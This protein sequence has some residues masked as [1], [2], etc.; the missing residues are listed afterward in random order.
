MICPH[1]QLCVCV[2][3][4]VLQ[5]QTALAAAAAAAT[6]SSGVV[7]GGNGNG[8]GGSSNDTSQITAH[9][10]HLHISTTSPYTPAT[11]T[12]HQQQ[13]TAYATPQ[14]AAGYQIPQPTAATQY[15]QHT[16]GGW[17]FSHHPTTHHHLVPQQVCIVYSVMSFNGAL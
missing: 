10:N 3:V 9:L 8:G 12:H 15:T 17:T 11:G 1:H 2:C 4:C 13:H 16:P 5:T 6:G 14:G 7:G